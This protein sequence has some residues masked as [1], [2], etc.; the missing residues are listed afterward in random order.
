MHTDCGWYTIT[1]ADWTKIEAKN[2]TELNSSSMFM[3]TGANVSC[4]IIGFHFRSMCNCWHTDVG[5]H[6]KS[7][8]KYT[9]Q[10][11]HLLPHVQTW[12]VDAWNY[13]KLDTAKH[14]MSVFGPALRHPNRT[15]L[16]HSRAFSRTLMSPPFK[17]T[18]EVTFHIVSPFREILPYWPWGFLPWLLL[19]LAP[20][21]LQLSQADG[22]K[23]IKYWAKASG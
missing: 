12:S 3:H 9:W 11:R 7:C 5:K 6:S 21:R 19:T 18:Q 10:M 13:F 14:V 16:K 4:C 20:R 17:Q 15:K 2:G 23:Q 22:W 1:K 8:H